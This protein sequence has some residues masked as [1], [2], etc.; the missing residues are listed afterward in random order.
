MLLR[1]T[2]K[3]FQKTLDSVKSFLSSG[4]YQR[5]PKTPPSPP[6]PHHPPNSGAG[7]GAGRILEIQYNSHQVI[8]NKV[9]SKST[10]PCEKKKK[11]GK[12]ITYEGKRYEQ[13]LKRKEEEKE[14]GIFVVKKLKELEMMDEKNAE[15]VL[16]IQEII[17]YYSRLTCPPYLHIVESFFLDMYSEFL[18]AA[19]ASHHLSR[20]SSYYYS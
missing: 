14:R 15:H 8:R 7:A 2:K 6:P 9:S 5:L 10:P 12:S 3:L 13:N 11:N 16:D 17:H 20:A 19:T 1:N 18:S 4:G